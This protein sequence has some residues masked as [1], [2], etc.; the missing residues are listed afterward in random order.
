MARVFTFAISLACLFLYSCARKE[1]PAASVKALVSRDS[2]WERM[3]TIPVCL[4]DSKG[5]DAQRWDI[6]KSVIQKQYN[7]RTPVRFIDFSTCPADASGHVRVLIAD[8]RPGPS[9]PALVGP[10]T[11]GV[12]GAITMNLTFKNDRADVCGAPERTETCIQTYALREFGRVLGLMPE[13]ERADNAC[14]GFG[15]G[16]RSIGDGRSSTW[17]TTYDPHSIMNSCMNEKQLTSGAPIRLSEGDVEI[18]RRLYGV[19]PSLPTYLEDLEPALQGES[20]FA[21]AK[22]IA[23]TK[24]H[25][26]LAE[27]R[28]QSDF[29]EGGSVVHSVLFAMMKSLITEGEYS[30]VSMELPWRDM[31]VLNEYVQGRTDNHKVNLSAF[32]T[33]ELEEFLEWLRKHNAT[34]ATKVDLAGFDI[35]HQAAADLAVIVGSMQAAGLM[36][37]AGRNAL[38]LACA[39]DA[40]DRKPCLANLGLWAEALAASPRPQGRERDFLE[41]ALKSRLAEEQIYLASTQDE[42]LKAFDARDEAMAFAYLTLHRHLYA[43]RRILSFGAFLHMAKESPEIETPF[44]KVTS[45]GTH[46]KRALGNDYGV[47]GTVA[48]LYTLEL[49]VATQKA[50]GTL[51]SFRPIVTVENNATSAVKHLSSFDRFLMFATLDGSSG[52]VPNKLADTQDFQAVPN[53]A[54]VQRDMGA[55]SNGTLVR[56]SQAQINEILNSA[57]SQ[58]YRMALP[59]QLAFTSLPRV[60]RL[61]E[62]LRLRYERPGKPRKNLGSVHERRCSQ[63]KD[64]SS[65]ATP[66]WVEYLFPSKTI[67]IEVSRIS[68]EER[69]SPKSIRGCEGSLRADLSPAS[70]ASYL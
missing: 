41:L 4:Q 58:K 55:I 61:G 20:A 26:A 50:D 24:S 54:D 19:L 48:H 59:R 11:L 34:S 32:G 35:Q 42:F 63:K 9:A 28:H 31:N 18:L 15:D 51:T 38:E 7:Q 16:F 65:L 69:C 45:M 70:W 52:S 49:E 64:T 67:R 36:D 44:G 8:E 13:H 43:Q 46:L 27:L 30:V 57:K 60:A 2:L 1:R 56:D 25:L 22:A 3:P 62:T 53:V 23:A 66:L 6:V 40:K 17:G 12:P 47:I 68:E 14:T 37:A 39:A 33:P 10:A 29:R 21:G 5:V